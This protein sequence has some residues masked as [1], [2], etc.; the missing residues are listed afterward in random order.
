MVSKTIVIA[1]YY[2]TSASR[3]SKFFQ[4]MHYRASILAY[5]IWVHKTQ[6]QKL[7]YAG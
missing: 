6:C 4:G 5:A 1:Y 7:S 2:R 3:I